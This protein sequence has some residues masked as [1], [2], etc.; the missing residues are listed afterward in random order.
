MA[1]N[2]ETLESTAANAPDDGS[3]QGERF[4]DGGCVGAAAEEIGSI[5]DTPRLLG[6]DPKDL[7]ALAVHSHDVTIH[8]A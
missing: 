4:G 1:L 2:G 6:S 5:W 7:R 3:Y 8:R